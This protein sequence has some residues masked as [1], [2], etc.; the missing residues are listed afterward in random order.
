MARPALK[1]DME[2]STIKSEMQLMNKRVE[3]LLTMVGGNSSY[4]VKGIRA[5]V[6]ELS[7]KVSAIESELEKIKRLNTDWWNTPIKTIP[8]KIAMVIAFLVML[9]TL[10]GSVKDLLKP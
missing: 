7:T 4:G 10:F 6:K 9:F 2:L 3:E 8:Q 1:D 5:D